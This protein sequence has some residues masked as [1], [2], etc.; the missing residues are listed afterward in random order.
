MLDDRACCRLSFCDPDIAS[1]K[2]SSAGFPIRRLNGGG[3]A[4]TVS[5]LYVYGARALRDVTPHTPDIILGLAVMQPPIHRI[6][7]ISKRKSPDLEGVY[8]GIYINPSHR[9]YLFIYFI[10]YTICK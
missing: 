10:Y 9:F 8:T 7:F 5:Y 3:S 2:M 1:N 6:Y 4:H